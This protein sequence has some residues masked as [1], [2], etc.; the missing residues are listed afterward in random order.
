MRDNLGNIDGKKEGAIPP[1]IPFEAA[2]A[3]LKPNLDKEA[4]RRKRRKRVF[5]FWIS[6]LAVGLISGLIV[7]N[8]SKKHTQATVKSTG[9]NI[10]TPSVSAVA[11]PL[12]VG[13]TLLEKY[14]HTN[15]T[16]VINKISPNENSAAVT[17]KRGVVAS[18]AIPL[19]PNHNNSVAGT[20]KSGEDN[21]AAKSINPMQD[22][23]AASE[24]STLKDAD[25]TAEKKVLAGDTVT[26][27]I[28]DSVNTATAAAANK[29]TP[30][31]INKKGIHFG[32][33]LNVP[34]ESGANSLDVN[35]KRQ[36]FSLLIPQL[37]IEKSISKK[38]R[39]LL[40]FNPY[41]QYYLNNKRIISA[42]N[43][44][45]TIQHGSAEEKAPQQITY[46]QQVSINKLIGIEAT[47][48]YRYKL[49]D[50]LNI[51]LG[52]A[53][54]WLQSAVIT[55]K[56]IENGTKVTH[57]SIIGIDKS[58][59]EWNLLKSNFVSGKLE[60]GYKY[61]KLEI[62]AVVCKPIGNISTNAFANKTPFNT[63]LFIRFYIK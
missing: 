39:L 32:L 37:F 57:D 24:S 55:N 44:N 6:I 26:K 7:M 42:N 48:M 40:A 13:K 10:A 35:G 3:T 15:E 36:P 62:G 45:V 16:V 19:N 2:W 58:S 8:E 53:N 28:S 41:S 50:K 21:N 11:L 38:Q 30:K 63:N 12:I 20:N 56:I 17:P 60:V 52:V 18:A 33:Q 25:K 29:L 22:S 59:K 46:V 4:A 1:A 54:N 47:L 31:L 23:Y 14:T 51:G 27:H 61:K 9:G 34:F 43:Y 49:S 5:F